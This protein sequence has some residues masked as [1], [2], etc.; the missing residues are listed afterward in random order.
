MLITIVCVVLSILLVLAFVGYYCGC[1]G[2]YRNPK[3]KGNQIRIACVGDSITYGMLIAGWPKKQYPLVL[4]KMLGEEYCVN[5]FGRGGRTAMY[6]G[7]FPY[8]NEKIFRKSLAFEPQIVVLKFGTNETKV[9]NWK[10]K[11]QFKE[12]YKKLIGTYQKL[13]TNPLLFLCTPATAYCTERG[14]VGPQF[15]NMQVEKVSEAAE[16]VI[17]LGAELGL[18]V[19]DVHAATANSPQWFIDGVHPNGA[20]AACI[21]KTVFQTLIEHH[22]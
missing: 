4:G 6:S 19:I 10:G 14:K 5:N 20:G 11:T 3:P 13:P 12:E 8:E 16:A 15:Y 9:N 18:P 17:E 21:A 2:C 22:C 1:S 7:D